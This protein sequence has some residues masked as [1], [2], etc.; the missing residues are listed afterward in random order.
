MFSE[1]DRRRF[2]ATTL[3]ASA[4]LAA[5]TASPPATA[6]SVIWIWLP[7]GIA[8]TDTWDPKSHTPYRAG[9]R[10]SELLGTCESI[11]TAADGVRIGAGLENIAKV[12]DR[13]CILRSLTSETRFGA[14]HLKAQHYMNTGYLFPAGV[15]APGIGAVVGRTLGRRDRNIPAYIYIGRDIDTS[16]EEKQFIGEYIGPGFYGPEH[17][18]FMIPDPGSG[19]AT[20]AAAAGM[21]RERLELRQRILLRAS[22]LQPGVKDSPQAA[23]WLRNMEEARAMMDSPVKAAFD[24]HSQERPETLRAYQP[25]IGPEQVR[26]KTYYYGHRFGHGLLLARRLVERGARFIQVEYQYGPFKGFDMHEHGRDRMVEMKRQIDQPISQLIRDLDERGL[27]KRTL[28]VIATEFGR[29]IASGRT[30]GREADGFAENHTGENLTIDTESMYGFHGHFSSSNAMLFFGGGF[31]QGVSYGRT[32]NRHPMTVVENP[33][34]IVDVHATIYRALGIPPDTHYV[35]E[36]R[37]FY[38]T[39]DGKGVPV[40]SLLV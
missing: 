14:V 40:A 21:S 16:D 10:G 6:D 25:A 23:L 9:M 12:M 32:A 29:T 17:A 22:A 2:L 27:L 15:K 11:P 39:K 19:L 1:M 38:A 8:Q 4:K 34:S 20:L 24:Y 3:G 26:D 31:R 13:G 36:G 28:V 33:V 7:G 18:P 35:T 30:A 37:P 5:A